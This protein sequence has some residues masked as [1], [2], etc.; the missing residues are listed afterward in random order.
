[1]TAGRDN[2]LW[3]EMQKQK[4][5]KSIGDEEW[6]RGRLQRSHISVLGP[7]EFY[8]RRVGGAP[9]GVAGPWGALEDIEGFVSADLASPCRSLTAFATA[10]HA[11]NPTRLVLANSDPLEGLKGVDPPLGET[12]AAQ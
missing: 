11:T 1:M 6:N 4:Q 9:H 3:L 10:K 2:E 8:R 5:G 7:R 12:H